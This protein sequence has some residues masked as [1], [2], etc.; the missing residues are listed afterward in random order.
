MNRFGFKNMIVML[1]LTVFMVLALSAPA[2][3]IS[4]KAKY[5][6]FAATAG[7]TLAVGDVVCI[8]ASDGYAYLADANDS[9]LR[10]AIGVIGKGGAAAATVEVVVQ[11]VI[12]GMTA[13][14]PG[15]R[16]FLSET[17]GDFTVTAPT[18]AQVLGWVLPGAAGAATSTTYFIDVKPGP[19]DGAGY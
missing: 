8:S 11:G 13:R 17:A 16:L 18:N 19:S 9:S 1:M 6:R 7:E 12:T 2:D 10:P 15:A 4:W 14:S 3:A 5:V